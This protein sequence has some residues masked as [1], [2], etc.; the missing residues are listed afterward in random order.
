MPSALLNYYLA[1]SSASLKGSTIIDIKRIMLYA[2]RYVALLRILFTW[3]AEL[4][5]YFI[6]SLTLNSPSFKILKKNRAQKVASTRLNSSRGI[7]HSSMKL[8]MTCSE[9]L[10]VSLVSL[11][12]SFSQVQLNFCF[13]ASYSSTSFE[14]SA[15]ALSWS[16]S[17]V[18][19]MNLF[20]LSIDSLQALSGK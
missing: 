9:F 7:M 2:C 14:R 8:E 17:R 11:F 10:M 19:L 3:I 16:L 1:C 6:V 13:I 5:M 12:F 20:S 18:E 4:L 15:F